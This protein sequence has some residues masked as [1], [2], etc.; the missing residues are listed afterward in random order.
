[1]TYYQ[2]VPDSSGLGN[3]INL[4][5]DLNR[6]VLEVEL[7]PPISEYLPQL[8]TAHLPYVETVFQSGTATNF[9]NYGNVDISGEAIVTCYY[10]AISQGTYSNNHFIFHNLVDNFLNAYSSRENFVSTGDDGKKILS[11]SPGVEIFNPISFQDLEILNKPRRSEHAYYAFQLRFTV[12][13]TIV[14]CNNE[15]A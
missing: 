5:Q 15:E 2:E 3:T 13:F 14:D 8:T 11:Y 9:L 6:K 12:K 4:I 7:A 10:E 1:M